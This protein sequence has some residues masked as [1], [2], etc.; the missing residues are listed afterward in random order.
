MTPRLSSTYTGD[1]PALLWWISSPSRPSILGMLGPH[2]SMS[3]N[4][5][6][7]TTTLCNKHRCR[8]DVSY[9]QMSVQQLCFLR[10]VTS[11]HTEQLLCCA[12]L[13]ERFVIR[14]NVHIGYANS[15]YE[16]R[17]CVSCA[18][19]IVVAAEVR[20]GAA[21]Q[22]L[23]YLFVFGSQCKCELCRKGAFANATLSR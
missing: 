6:C 23:P 4:P 16:T 2:M 17:T 3:S 18:H 8:P 14:M 13:G 5:T 1:Q 22:R 19:C 12:G 20:T 7:A 11:Q 21:E 15:Q 10:L 9:R